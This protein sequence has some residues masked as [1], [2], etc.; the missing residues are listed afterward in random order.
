MR[1]EF[2]P[3]GRDHRSLVR[4][5]DYQAADLNHLYKACCKLAD[6]LSAEVA[7]HEQSWVETIGEG[8]LVLRRGSSDIGVVQPHFGEPFVLELTAEGSRE[9][10]DKLLVFVEGCE[11]SIGLL[12]REM[13]IC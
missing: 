13:S 8:R 1:I 2:I 12:T 5:F 10:A 9:V 6:S 11:A 7:L 3:D 4:L